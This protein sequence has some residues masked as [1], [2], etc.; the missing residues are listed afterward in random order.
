MSTVRDCVTSA[1]R[2]IGVT[3]PNGQEVIDAARSFS[4]MVH[5]WRLQGIDVWHI[6]EALNGG[7]PLPEVDHGEF[8]AES[9]FPMPEAYREAAAYCLAEKMAPE[10]GKQV[11]ATKYLRMIQAGYINIL[12]VT[13]EPMLFRLGPWRRVFT[14]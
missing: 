13:L 12:P 8:T 5:G 1:L 3:D 2:K 9:P 14:A 10:Y 4:D 6:G 7:M 11:D